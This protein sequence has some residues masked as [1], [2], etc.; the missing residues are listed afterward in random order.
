MSDVTTV[1]GKELLEMRRGS[2][3]QGARSLIG[4]VALLLAFSVIAP[5]LAGAESFGGIGTLLI[6]PMVAATWAL[7]S[8]PDAFAG[9]RERHTLE[10]LLTTRLPA[11]AILVGKVLANVASASLV[12]IL[13][14]VASIVAGN[15]G[16]MVRHDQDGIDVQWL[17][18]GLGVAATGLTALLVCNLGILVALRASSAMN[19][20]R[21]LGLGLAG[22][23]LLLSWGVQALPQGLQSDLSTLADDIEGLSVAA[24]VAL[25][26]GV[27]VVLNLALVGVTLARFTRPKLV[28]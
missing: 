1:M 26:V 23:L 7:T 11:R 3:N 27:Y 6:G 9:E 14:I 17:E 8:V 19:A 13:G 21:A 28:R 15:V 20:Q 12:G 10:T 2:G 4:L 22:M 24:L 18:A 25:G 16:G 5:F